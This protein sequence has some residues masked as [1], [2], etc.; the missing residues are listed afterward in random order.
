MIQLTLI[1]LIILV[2]SHFKIVAIY[3]GAERDTELVLFPGLPRQHLMDLDILCKWNPL[4]IVIL[5]T[6][7]VAFSVSAP[8]SETAFP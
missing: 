1:D 4:N 7:E 2:I 3:Q 6:K 8:F 5:W